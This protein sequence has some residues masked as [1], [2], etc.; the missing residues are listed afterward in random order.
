MI[1]RIKLTITARLQFLPGNPVNL[2]F[3]NSDVGFTHILLKGGA[4]NTLPDGVADEDDGSAEESAEQ[5][6]DQPAEADNDQRL[7]EVGLVLKVDDLEGDE[8]APDLEDLLDGEAHIGHEDEEAKDIGG[9][10]KQD[11]SG[12]DSQ[13]DFDIKDEV[14]KEGEEDKAQTSRL[15]VNWRPLRTILRTKRVGVTWLMNRTILW[16]INREAPPRMATPSVTQ[17][18]WGYWATTS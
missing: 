13:G 5:D 14:A 17:K 12:R 7:E 1:R 10:G 3:G 2:L 15:M 4:N 9:G 11:D 18:V 8:Q 16:P 6:G